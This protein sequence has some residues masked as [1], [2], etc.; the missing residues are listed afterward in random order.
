M[1]SYMI[2][3]RPLIKRASRPIGII[4]RNV[5]FFKTTGWTQDLEDA[6]TWGLRPSPDRRALLLDEAHRRSMAVHAHLGPASGLGSEARPLEP[7]APPA[8]AGAATG[9]RRA[10]CAAPRGGIPACAPFCASSSFAWG[11]S[12]PARPGAAG[13]VARRVRLARGEGRGVSD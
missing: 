12:A 2:T 11:V 3:P 7:S 5:A 10:P 9:L 6:I 4:S 1:S 8:L 13:C